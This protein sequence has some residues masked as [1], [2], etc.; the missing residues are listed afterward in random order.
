VSVPDEQVVEAVESRRQILAARGDDDMIPLADADGG[1]DVLPH[2]GLPPGLSTADNGR[3]ADV[4]ATRG[5]PGDP[6]LVAGHGR[7]KVETL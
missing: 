5:R 1:T 3:L 4:T 7:A 6:H 2:D